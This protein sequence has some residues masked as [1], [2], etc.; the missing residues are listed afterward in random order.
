MKTLRA[1][2]ALISLFTV[3]PVK[4]NTDDIYMLSERF[5]LT[6]SIGALFGL[7]SALTLMLSSNIIPPLA[8]ATMALT[9]VHA[10]NGLL[11]VDGLIDFGDGIAAT[12]S[13]TE[14]LKAMKDESAGSGGVTIAILITIMTIALLASLPENALLLAPFAA[15]VLAKNSIVTCAAL[16]KPKSEGIGK[17][18][19]EHPSVKDMLLSTSLSISLLAPVVWIT[20]N[21]TP[22]DC[23][24]LAMLILPPLCSSHLTAIFISKYAMKTFGCITGD[25][26]GATNEI[27]RTITLLTIIL[28]IKCLP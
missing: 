15:E 1:I 16:G 8:S 20:K 26:L 3:L 6:P 18:F 10:I 28:V 24:K 11:H 5:W 13:K 19:I 2:K 22:I 12:G 7:I 9:L 4:A 17:T 23:I 25:V 21:A 14:K 27:S